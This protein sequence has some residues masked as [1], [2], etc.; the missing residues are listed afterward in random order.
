[1]EFFITKLISMQNFDSIS[2]AK[3]VWR[4]KNFQKSYEA[5]SELTSMKCGSISEILRCIWGV[6]FT[7]LGAVFSSHLFWNFFSWNGLR[8]WNRNEIL[9]QNEI[10]WKQFHLAF[11]LWR[12]FYALDAP[13]ISQYSYYKTGCIVSPISFLIFFFFK[14]SS[15]LKL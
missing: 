4:K 10:S 3:T 11:R 9:L 6:C 14:R 5:N 7:E 13:C 8:Q 1:M 2:L 12:W 15:S